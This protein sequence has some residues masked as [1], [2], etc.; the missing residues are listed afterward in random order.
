M[1]FSTSDK[2]SSN[3]PGRVGRTIGHGRATGLNI[4]TKCQDVGVNGWPC[5]ATP[6]RREAKDGEARGVA[7]PEQPGRRRIGPSI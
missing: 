1:S 2:F 7:M 4:L 5:T 3:L 6:A